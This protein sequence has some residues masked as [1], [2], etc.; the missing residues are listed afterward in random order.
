VKV[1]KR[2]RLSRKAKKQLAKLKKQL[3][4][5]RR[6]T[7]RVVKK[8]AK[9]AA[10][11]TVV[12]MPPKVKQFKLRPSKSKVAVS[13][14]VINW[15][16]NGR[17]HHVKVKIYRKL[18]S[19]KR[20]RKV[21]TIKSNGDGFWAAMLPPG[22]YIVVTKKK[23]FASAPARMT[24]EKGVPRSRISTGMSPVPPG[25]G[26]R[27]VLTWG[28]HPADL[29]SHLTLPGNRCHV[30][31]YKRVC[32]NWGVASL[33]LDATRGNGPETIT[34]S[35]PK[36][37]TYI[38]TVQQY[39]KDGTLAKSEGRVLVFSGK[40]VYVFRAGKAAKGSKKNGKITGMK[41]DVVKWVVDKDGNG[42][43]Q[44]F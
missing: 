15:V 10:K 16:N 2:I 27:F 40:K 17:I 25:K 30:A 19:G 33:D 23:G 5:I 1:V 20:G 37:G 34:I 41:W 39:S 3:K 6:K 43:I 31:Y 29:D 26:T 44:Y 42:K 36:E 35:K 22:K 32:N 8:A 4:T 38:Y 14:S 9:K 18:K 13:G 21:R 12:M 24:L 11:K 7:I 28:D